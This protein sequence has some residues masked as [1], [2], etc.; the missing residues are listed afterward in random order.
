MTFEIT[1]KIIVSPLYSQGIFFKLIQLLKKR[2]RKYL[3]AAGVLLLIALFLFLVNRV[4]NS[5]LEDAKR[6]HQQA[7]RWVYGVRIFHG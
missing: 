3:V 5:T 1:F 6:N 2:F 7:C 4:Y